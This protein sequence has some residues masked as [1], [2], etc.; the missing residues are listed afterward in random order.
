MAC[1]TRGSAVT[2]LILPREL[3]ERL[4]P[5][6]DYAPPEDQSGATDVH[7][8]DHWARTLR[9][10][11]LCHRLDMTL[12]GEPGS[13]RTLV[14]SRHCC[15]DLL[16]YFLSP[17]TTWE[18]HFEDVVIQVLKENR[19]HL[20]TKHAK[21]VTSLANCNRRRT[22]L[23]GEIDTTLEAMQMVTDR[24]S[25]V[26]L[27]HR[28]N[29]LQTSL[30]AIEWAITKYEN[31]LEDCRMQEEEAHQE[32]AISQEWEEEEGDA[33]AE[34]M[35]E[36]E[37][38]NGEP[39]GPQGAAGT[40]EVPPLVSAGDAISPEEDAFLMQ[41]ASQPVDPTAGSHS[42]RSEAG[43]VSGEMAELSLTSPSQPGPGEDKTPQ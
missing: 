10:A 38:E 6:A 24:A 23:R 43:T 11:I 30:A 18:L 14:R 16:A 25:G 13:S 9:V 28:L 29:S 4:P 15:G 39:S 1:V 2:S 40:E 17:R 42:P 41:Q 36:E 3:A 37:R 31:I 35:E 26:E 19:R 8:R 34:M 32:E 7:I 5:L 33:N 27:E 22:N 20:E 21:A 12:R